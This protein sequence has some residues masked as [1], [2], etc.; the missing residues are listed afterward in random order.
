ML[1]EYMASSVFNA[2]SGAA[3]AVASKI[4]PNAN[5]FSYE[6][7]ANR[8][9]FIAYAVVWAFMDFCAVPKDG[10]TDVLHFL[11]LV[12]ITLFLM[13]GYVLALGKFARS[14]KLAPTLIVSVVYGIV[15][16]LAI[17]AVPAFDYSVFSLAFKI[18]TN[19]LFYVLVVWLYWKYKAV[20]AASI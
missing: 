12:G 8:Y 5:V 3:N 18:A 11:C 14:A 10:Q 13:A 15:A 9:A 16:A 2:A 17:N 4:D 6:K 7:I 19:C 20:K 1:K